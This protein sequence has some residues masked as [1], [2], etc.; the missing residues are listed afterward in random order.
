MTFRLA[1][2]GARNFH[3]EKFMFEKIDKVIEKHGAPSM[4]VSGGAQ[5]ADM[6]AKKYAETHQI[7]LQE[8]LPLYHECKT[9][10]EK[11]YA[12]L[13]RNLLIVENCDMLL[14][15]PTEESRGTFHTITHAEKQSKKVF[16]FSNIHV[17]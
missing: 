8:F 1:V 14:A 12:P 15:F 6:L 16:I 10:A 5:G 13:K 2:V 4:I 11:R 17:K 3:D 9:N 7:P